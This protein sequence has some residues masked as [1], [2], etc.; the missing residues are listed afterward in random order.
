MFDSTIK[1]VKK[2][3]NECIEEPLPK[4]GKRCTVCKS[5]GKYLAEYLTKTVQNNLL[6]KKKKLIGLLDINACKT[7]RFLV[8][9]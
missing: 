9:H 4:I 5:R 7:L 6:L 1:K 8:V 2:W 3:M